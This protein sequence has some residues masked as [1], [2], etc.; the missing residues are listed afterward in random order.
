MI[1]V[2]MVQGK[3]RIII[4]N[5]EWEFGNSEESKKMINQLLDYKDKYGRIK[6]A[7]ARE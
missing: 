6:N 1:K 5:E 4:E 7:N 2:N 3:W